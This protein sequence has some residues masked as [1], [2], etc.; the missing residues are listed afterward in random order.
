MR[1]PGTQQGDRKQDGAPRAAKLFCIICAEGSPR[2]SPPNHPHSAHSSHLRAPQISL[3][4][5]KKET[6]GT[7]VAPPLGTAENKLQ[8]QTLGFFRA[9]SPRSGRAAS[10]GVSQIA[11]RAEPAVCAWGCSSPAQRGFLHPSP[12]Q[13]HHLLTSTADTSKHLKPPALYL[14]GHSTQHSPLPASLKILL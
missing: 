6:A 11:H 13:K 4:Q 3:L 7:A 5:P 12:V 8:T 10:R 2:Q 1:S 14:Y 9:P